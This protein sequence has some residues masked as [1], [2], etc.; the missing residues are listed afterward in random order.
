MT[1]SSGIT[2]LAACAALAACVT[3]GCAVPRS[4]PL[5]RQPATHPATARGRLR[6][7]LP[8]GSPTAPAAPSSRP[9]SNQQRAS[10]DAAAILASF[11]PPPGA[12]RLAAAPAADAG[13]LRQPMQTPGAFHL[14][15]KASW[16]QAPGQP[17]QVLGWERS[18]LPRR[19]AYAGD[20]SGGGRGTWTMWGDQFTLPSVP[21][22]LPGRYFLVEVVGAGGGQTAIR[23]DAQVIWLPA[24]T[25]VERVPSAAEVVTV[26]FLPG[27]GPGGTA[28]LGPVTITGAATVRRIAALVDGLPLAPWEWVSC[29]VFDGGGV[30]LT[31]RARAG[32]PALATLSATVNGCPPALLTVDGKQ[33]PQLSAGTSFARQV[34]ALAG[35]RLPGATSSPGG[36]MEHGP[37][38]A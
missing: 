7:A 20:A 23:V 37:A 22:V 12:R 28:R 26:A 35:L 34:A 38:P 30:R 27:I 18:H 25:A 19:F 10:A 36:V 24:K 9:A 31:F 15:D 13:M 11:V 5:A 32:G 3:T 4:Q 33:Q 6:A 14:I 21:G 16:W 8:Q 2:A 1:R 29:P 17:R